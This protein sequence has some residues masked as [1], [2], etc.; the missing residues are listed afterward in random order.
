VHGAGSRTWT[1]WF[2]GGFNAYLVERRDSLS[3]RLFLA[4]LNYMLNA[5]IGDIFTVL[6]THRCAMT[7]ADRNS[8]GRNPDVSAMPELPLKK[9][10][11]TCVVFLPANVPHCVLVKSVNTTYRAP[12]A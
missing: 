7:F 3:R 2:S 5:A 11:F 9:K 12:L 10:Y 4:K 8:G 6:R 1:L